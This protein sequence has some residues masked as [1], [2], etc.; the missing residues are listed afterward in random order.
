[1]GA[2]RRDG[3]ARKKSYRTQTRAVAARGTAIGTRGAAASRLLA[4]AVV[5]VFLFTA[6]P[7]L[8]Q[9]QLSVVGTWGGAVN[10]VF[11][12]ESNPD[13]AFVCVGRQFVILDVG[14]PAH[15]VELGLIDLG[16]NLPVNVIGDVMDVAVR[17]GKAFVARGNLL[18]VDVSNLTDPRL[19]WSGSGNVS[20][21][22]QVRLYNDVAY[23]RVGVDLHVYD[24]SNLEA[25][26]HGGVPIQSIVQDIKIVGDLMYMVD[27][28]QHVRIYDL[29]A[30]PFHPVQL[31]ITTLPGNEQSGTAIDVEGRYAY[32]TTGFQEG[33]LAI[34]D[35]ST[36]AAPFVA[37]SFDTQFAD[38][39]A[40]SNG[41][42]YLIDAGRLVVLDVRNPASINVSATFQTNARL[43][44]VELVGDR[45]Y[46]WDSGEGLIILDI[47]GGDGPIRLGNWHSP[48]DLRKMQRVGDLLYVTDSANGFSVLDLA[49]P[50]VPALVSVYQADP[51]AN[52]LLDIEIRNDLA[53]LAAGFAGIEI[54]D[55]SD[56]ADPAFLGA[57]RFP[58]GFWSGALKLS[59]LNPSIAHVGV[60]N[61]SNHSM[62]NF[63][64]AEPANIFDVGFVSLGNLPSTIATTSEG[65][66]F[67]ARETGATVV[68]TDTG[69][70][71]S[72]AAPTVIAQQS[73][74][75][76]A[77]DLTLRDSL[78]YVAVKDTNEGGL[79]IYDVSVP[80]SPG[81]L[82]RF[83]TRRAYGV[84]VQ[85]NVAYL[86]ADDP[87]NGGI[88]TLFALDV[89][90]PGA[91]AVIAQSELRA[92]RWVLVDGGMIHVTTIAKGLVVLEWT[93][94]PCPG[95]LNGDRAVDLAD[96][97]ILLAD[98]GCT[99]GGC[100][101]DVDG[102][103]DTDLADL[104]ILLANFGQ[105]CP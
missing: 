96:L 30:D 26:Q 47:S 53:Y 70:G 23:V 22:F 20:R 10:A 93:G 60:T 98:F 18:V 25:P 84:A 100:P 81:L 15:I 2:E 62:V 24:I 17:D 82:G 79:F 46:V 52:D 105:N 50:A 94:M 76:R 80:A 40:V 33:M 59:A 68:D 3:G 88:T 87:A 69:H 7:A 16:Q 63:N 12:D 91:P 75:V 58:A 99:G 11:V 41:V 28:F 92:A 34:V 85:D 55:V 14:D 42:A 103:G 51:I 101:G 45:A 73:P 21:A 48:Q 8:A 13:I 49:D 37:G 89:S 39:V 38:D 1:M 95:D 86:T 90:D 71:G 32:A 72:G 67:V 102:D 66:G 19:I 6:A 83:P 97:G 65:I 27:D 44:G 36:P 78:L 31:G 64:I 74:P 104:G 9:P 4:A 54:V 29:S 56:P 43:M 35:V 5:L 61:G 57:F 77:M